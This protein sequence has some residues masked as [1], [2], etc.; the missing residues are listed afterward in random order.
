MK[1]VKDTSEHAAATARLLAEQGSLNVEVY[2]SDKGHVAI[3]ARE[4][5]S[6][7]VAKTP[8]LRWHIS[9]RGSRGV[10]AWADLVEIGHTLRPGVVFCVGVPPRTWWLN[11]HPDVLHLWEISDANLIASW[12]N[13]A[14]GHTPT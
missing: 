3:M 11:V 7:T 2:R 6:A 8:D 9:V 13:E 4:P 5:V 1:L 12:R 10:P 14:M